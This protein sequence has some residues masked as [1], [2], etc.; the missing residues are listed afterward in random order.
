MKNLTIIINIL[1][2][3]YAECDY[4]NDGQL[5]ILD[6]VEQVDCIL[7]DCWTTEYEEGEDVQDYATVLINGQ[8]WMAE[9]L[10]TIYFNNGDPINNIEWDEGWTYNYE[11]AYA[12]YNEDPANSDIYGRLYNQFAIN[13]ER[14]I[15]PID[16]HVPSQQEYID[17]AEY[18]G[19]MNMAGYRM[20]HDSWD[21]D[22]QVH[23][24]GLPA[25]CR[26]SGPANGDC[27]MG[28]LAQFWTSTPL[29][30]AELETNKDTLDFNT[31]DQRA[32]KSVR[33]VAD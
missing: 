15:C 30:Y 16:W 22:N 33:C 32:G 18:L 9:N 5:N 31:K 27:C 17:L 11:P 13:D 6:I 28:I 24:N 10:N 23:F 29:V 2:L 4:N 1:A 19:G 12:N 26:D 8:L 7:N 21:G 14:G 3:C 20:K 25:G